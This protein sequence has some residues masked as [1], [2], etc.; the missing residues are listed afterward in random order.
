MLSVK[1]SYK[2]LKLVH[3]ISLCFGMLTIK[4]EPR[5]MRFEKRSRIQLF[6]YSLGRIMFVMITF[7]TILLKIEEQYR[8]NFI[9]NKQ[10]ILSVLRAFIFYK[11]IFAIFVTYL[12]ITKANFVANFLNDL[13]NLILKFNQITKMNAFSPN[14]FLVLLLKI[15]IG[16]LIMLTIL[17]YAALKHELIYIFNGLLTFSDVMFFNILSVGMLIF[18]NLH[19]MRFLYLGSKQVLRSR[20][21][22]EIFILSRNLEKL[23]NAFTKFVSLA[24]LLGIIY[25]FIN[26]S[27]CLC[28]IITSNFRA[29]SRT[30]TTMVST[31][32]SLLDVLLYFSFGNYMSH[33]ANLKNLNSLETLD[34]PEEKELVCYFTKKNRYLSFNKYILDAT[35]GFSIIKREHKALSDGIVRSG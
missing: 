15:G 14:I 23:C 10:D 7:I 19:K 17:V 30:V 11:I 21:A 8:S 26:I 3:I 9:H 33:G 29:D 12:S 20:E 5:L 32:L 18:G 13:Y 28:L 2:V 35:A 31:L 16:F 4:F 24:N 22:R 27:S 34:C 1:F 25:F 6:A